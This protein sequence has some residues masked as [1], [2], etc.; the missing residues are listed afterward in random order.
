MMPGSG[1][2]RRSEAAFETVIEAHPV[3]DGDVRLDCGGFDFERVVRECC[4]AIVATA[5][6]GRIDVEAAG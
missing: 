1:R 6:T 4:C 2:I 5:V 3:A